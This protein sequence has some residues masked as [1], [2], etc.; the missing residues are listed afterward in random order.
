ML[1]LISYGVYLWH[2]PVYVV[3]DALRTGLD[4][5][6]LL[7]V[8]IAVTLVIAGTSY[9]IVEQP[10]RRGFGSP[11]AWRALT[12]V[13]GLL[14]VAVVFAVTGDGRRPEPA[15]A[16]GP[17][18]ESSARAVHQAVEQPQASRILVVG[19][20]VGWYL[21]R[22]L[23]EVE[24]TTPKVVLDAALPACVFPS[25]ASAMRFGT[26]IRYQDVR[27]CDPTWTD[28]VTQFRPDTV[29][30]VYGRGA[31]AEYQYGAGWLAPC[32][33]PYDRFYRAELEALIKRF[34]ALRARVVVT[35]DA[36]AAVAAAFPRIAD[37]FLRNTDCA[38]RVIRRAV[39][40]SGAQLA[41]L[42][43]FTCPGGACRTHEDGVEL[44]SDGI[45][46]RDEGARIVARWILRQLDFET[47]ASG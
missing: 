31:P 32:T 13:S 27:D 21:G 12:P 36:Y 6:A 46:Y 33:E 18:A 39:R 17:S 43:E 7:A 40:S 16:A 14:L 35:T 37:S 42:F 47:S 25:G 38:N 44:R 4:D 2:W 28:D 29:L 30:F 24:T 19:N 3:L 20:S 45:H 1:G 26:Q 34:Q 8:R 41:D 22:A 15:V 11:F 5:H 23:A 9:V 10:V